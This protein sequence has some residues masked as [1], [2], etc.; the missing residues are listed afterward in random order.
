MWTRNLLIL[1]C[2]LAPSSALA[3]FGGVPEGAEVIPTPAAGFF[4]ADGH[5]GVRRRA[6]RSVLPARRRHRPGT[7]GGTPGIGSTGVMTAGNTT[8][9]FRRCPVGTISGR[10]ASANCGRSKRPSCSGEA[11]RAI[12]IARAHCRNLQESGPGAWPCPALIVWREGLP[13]QASARCAVPPQAFSPR[14]APHRLR[15]QRASS[16]GRRYC[17]TRDSRIS[18]RGSKL[19]SATVSKDKA[20]RPPKITR[21][22]STPSSR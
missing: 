15:P 14:A 19:R 9:I 11:I 13:L 4:S 18:G 17:A 16:P 3:A 5:A 21:A 7:T 6:L 20:I 8:P 2:C 12:P 1:A 22:S 10:T